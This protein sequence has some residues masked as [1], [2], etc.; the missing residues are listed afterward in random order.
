[1]RHVFSNCIKA[2]ENYYSLQ[3]RKKICIK[4]KSQIVQQNI[5]EVG[6][7]EEK[8]QIITSKICISSKILAFKATHFT[9]WYHIILVYC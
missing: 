8:L 7:W 2:Y 6:N 4:I 1:M 9:S 5:S 3:F